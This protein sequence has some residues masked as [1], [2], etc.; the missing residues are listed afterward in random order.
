[1]SVLDDICNESVWSNFLFRKEEVQHYPVGDLQ[2]LRRII[3][4]E[5]SR[6]GIA[7]LTRK[8]SKGE[9]ALSIPQKRLIPKSR[10]G[11]K[12]EVYLFRED[13]AVVLKIMNYLLRRYDG[14]FSDNLYSYRSSVGVK[15]AAKRLFNDPR[16]RRMYVQDRHQSLFQQH[17]SGYACF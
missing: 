13:E 8:I 12:R 4:G 11:K 9:Y 6:P 7:D 16:L 5:G 2:V 10:F 15:D 17:R 3:Y 14:I 1:M